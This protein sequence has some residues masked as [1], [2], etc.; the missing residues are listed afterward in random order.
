[1]D[2]EVMTSPFKIVKATEDDVS[3]ILS[4]WRA[5]QQE[6]DAAVMAHCKMSVLES[7]FSAMVIDRIRDRDSL[8][9]LLRE[10]RENIGFSVAT[11]EKPEWVKESFGRIDALYVLSGSRGRGAG[12]KMLDT[13]E[14][15]MQLHVIRRVEIKV[16]SSFGDVES[17][18]DHFGYT[19][20]E[21]RMCKKLARL[22]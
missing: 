18:C 19:A 20:A 6:L 8:V 13:V 15:W 10:D 2:G 12:R 14:R 1:M 9:I 21:Y 4:L 16:I 11:I 17:I 5:Y 22:K 7:D 3:T